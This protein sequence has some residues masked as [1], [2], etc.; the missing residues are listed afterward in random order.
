VGALGKADFAEQIRQD[1]VDVLVDTVG[2]GAG[3]KLSALALHPAP[4]QLSW[5]N[6]CPSGELPGVDGLLV[7]A[8]VAG[9][10]RAVHFAGAGRM[11]LLPSIGT[12]Q[13]PALAAAEVRAQA[14]G[15]VLGVLSP[16]SHI[17]THVVDAWAEL[18]LALPE[19]TLLVASPLSG[20]DE[21][22]RNRLKRLFMLRDVAPDRIQFESVSDSEELAAAL[23]RMTVVL[24]SFPVTMGLHHALCSLWVGVPVV[25][26]TG[27][28]I[29]QRW[30]LS[31]LSDVGLPEWAADSVENYIQIVLAN[32]RQPDVLC[33][34]RKQL[35]VRL[36]SGPLLDSSGF[37]AGFEKALLSLWDQ[38]VPSQA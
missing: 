37:A 21:M 17:N 20:V 15:C 32:V 7:S 4:I 34:L 14:R 6:D 26:M 9:T 25:T 11:L 16:L 33:E 27:P 19:A 22:V 36:A 35:P 29:W 12:W 8:V 10:E 5:L 2:L 3:S 18:L 1:A 28:E 13:P 23:A 31:V 24:D 38:S 30:T